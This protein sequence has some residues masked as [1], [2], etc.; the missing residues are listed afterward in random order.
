MGQVISFLTG[1]GLAISLLVFFVGLAVRIILYFKGLDW[2]L[3]RVAYKAFL[4]QGMKGGVHSAAKWLLPYG[5]YGWRAQPFFALCFFL[6]HFGAVLIPFFLI[7]HNEVLEMTF[8]FSFPSMPQGL[9]DA[10]TIAAIVG[11]IFIILRRIALPEVRILTTAYD[12][13][14]IALAAAP[15]VTGFIA[16]LGGGDGWLLAHIV[17]GEVMLILAPF[18][19]LSHIVLYFASRWQIGADYSIKRGGKSRGPCFPW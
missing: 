10:L 7:G 16:R 18:T 11:I 19:K 1:P 3:E 2:R 12:Y 17:S 9:A 6:F 14:I 8:G 4:G 13:C 5:T 15:F